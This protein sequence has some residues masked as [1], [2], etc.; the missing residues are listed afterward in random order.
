M[1]L[2]TIFLTS[3]IMM[4]SALHAET[5]SAEQSFTCK[6]TGGVTVDSLLSDPA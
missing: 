1:K 2:L 5:S 4:V 3:S 6:V